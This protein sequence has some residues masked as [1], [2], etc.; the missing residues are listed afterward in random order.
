M[1]K[2]IKKFF[3]DFAKRIKNK[4][5]TKRAPFLIVI[6]I[7]I[8]LIPT[9]FAV[10]QTYFNRDSEFFS[11]DEISVALYDEQ[12]NI[13]SKDTISV[14][15]I[16]DSLLARMLYGI[17]SDVI[18]STELL[19][20][21]KNHNYVLETKAND[22]VKT[23]RCF[24]SHTA[25]NSY[26]VD[27]DNTVYS[28]D[29]DKYYLFLNS[30][31]SEAVYSSAAPPSLI[32]S[33]GDTVTPSQIAW[34]YTRSD[35]TI[36]SALLSETDKA[37]RLY[38]MN[39]LI[40]LN[41][42]REPDVCAVTVTDEDKNELYHGNMADL[43]YLT[44]D[45]Q[46]T[47]YVNISSKWSQSEEFDS[48]GEANY[49]FRVICTN[50]VSFEISNSTVCPG[51][52]IELKAYDT[53]EG[54]SPIYAVIPN[55][56]NDTSIF[57]K[58]PPSQN[59]F[60]SSST[61]LHF[62]REYTPVFAKRGNVLTALVP[63]PE[64]TPSG[65]FSFALSSGIATSSFEI[66]ITTR[67]NSAEIPTTK[68]RKEISNLTSKNALYE[69]EKLLTMLATQAIGDP[70]FH[71][72]FLSP[73]DYSFSQS[74]TFGDSFVTG[75]EV[76]TAFSAIGNAY[77]SNNKNQNVLS[78]NVGK[79]IYTGNIFA[80]GNFVIVDHGMGLHTWYCNLG[81]F[82]VANGDIVAKG[83]PLGKIGTSTMLDEQGV[84]I[85]A[86][87]RGTLIDPSNILGQTIAEI[88]TS[89]SQEDTK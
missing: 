64:N 31:Y 11:A 68:S 41:F 87:I 10:Y 13:I 54:S 15:N 77:S 7:L 14:S 43:A 17:E 25:K 23:F 40:M 38:E 34:K 29:E 61:A 82:D 74:Y 2:D 58:A 73:K 33:S 16:S 86:S 72:E 62:L 49:S 76:Y 44:V 69:V 51:D 59:S 48:Y 9:L 56:E 78:A 6:A 21:L 45:A 22:K 28:V 5:F 89:P 36:A 60:L 50:Y 63:I 39:G 24:F 42:S 18:S 20:S 8:I 71:S 81:S 85:L 47:I 30:D 70:Y 37:S 26:L 75:K 46:T 19:T 32:T 83:Q 84:L 52:V 1:F 65:I 3:A 27:Q 80:L 12:K 53:Q 57:Y 66:E 79:V 55:E 4:S 35:G 88:Q 67:K